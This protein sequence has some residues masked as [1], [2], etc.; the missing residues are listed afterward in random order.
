MRRPVLRKWEGRDHRRLWSPPGFTVGGLGREAEPLVVSAGQLAA[1][2]THGTCSSL[3][4]SIK[5]KTCSLVLKL[6]SPLHPNWCYLCRQSGSGDSLSAHRAEKVIP[7][8]ISCQCKASPTL[9][10]A[11]MLFASLQSSYLRITE[12]VHEQAA[13]IRVGVGVFRTALFSNIV[14]QNPL[15]Y[16]KSL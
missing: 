3:K 5:S 11:A 2:G 1:T 8:S 14:A 9:C 4:D 6:I 10:K 12:F 15:L 7:N 16:Q 13:E